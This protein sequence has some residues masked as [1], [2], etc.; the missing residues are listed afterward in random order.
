MSI[1][2]DKPT[3]DN[4]LQ[5]CKGKEDIFGEGGLIK[6]F[7]KAVLERALDA[8]MQEHLGYA[9]HDPVGKNTGNSRNGYSKKTVSGDSGEIELE[10]PRD[11]KDDF[12]PEIV[13]KGQ[14]RIAGFDEKIISLY[15]RG[16]TTRDI[17]S[18]LKELY[19]V[20]V[21]P[22]LISS[23]TE[24]VMEEVRTWQNRT[25]DK[26]YPIV[27]LDALVVKIKEEKQA[28]NKA[29]H[30]ALGIN[31]DGSKEF[32]G[33][34]ITNN[35]G[36]KF[37]LS[38]LT[39]LKNRGLQD[40]FIACIDGLTGFPEAISIVYPATKVQLCIVHMIRNSLRFVPWKDKKE[41]VA[42][43]KL[44]YEA[45]AID[46]AELNLTNFAEKWDKK[47]PNISRSWLEKWE[48]LSVFFAYPEEIRRIIYTTNAIESLNMTVR[49]V[50]KNKRF[51]PSDD[52]AFKQIFLAIRNISKRWTMP[53]RNWNEA[54]TRF[55]IEF[56]DRLTGCIN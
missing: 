46:Q 15:A 25:L 11:R 41:V 20:D 30:L 31:L 36:S 56:G 26:I 54:M 14:T 43:L 38:V 7:T 27:Y 18:Q 2:F 23:V 50:L 1:K 32:L 42:D 39:E 9:K 17:Q 12:Q 34:R 10:I 6:A 45:S 16:M 48:H 47:Y 4:L 40:I 22:T 24:S 35:E 51:F 52:A 37:W 13:K 8:E 44:I 21:S 19:D 5:Q 28:V 53:I 49:K 29:I 33:M 55:M 3:I